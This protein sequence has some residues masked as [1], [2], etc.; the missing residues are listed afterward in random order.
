MFLETLGIL[1][2]GVRCRFDHH[3]AKNRS[4][5]NAVLIF[6][7]RGQRPLFEASQDQAL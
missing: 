5:A 2:K 7:A 6:T 3:A 1:E 4:T